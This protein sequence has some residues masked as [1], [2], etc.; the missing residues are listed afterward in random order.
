MEQLVEERIVHKGK[1]NFY[2]DPKDMTEEEQKEFLA[3][4]KK[5]LEN[6]MNEFLTNPINGFKL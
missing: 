6:K 2:V 5:S 4:V 1:G 3:R